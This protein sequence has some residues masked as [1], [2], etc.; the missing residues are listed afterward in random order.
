MQ[1]QEKRICP[2]CG[3]KRKKGVPRERASQGS[4]IDMLMPD[5]ICKD[6]GTRYA[7]QNPKS[8]PWLIIFLGV[9]I[10]LIG[11][12][13]IFAP[14]TMLKLTVF[15]YIGVIVGG[16][17]LIGYGIYKLIKPDPPHKP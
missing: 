11:I 15:G 8:A 16:P 7:V 17:G 13:F 10:L 9:L 12:V 1:V 3:S 2:N 6:C 5:F 14:K 4:L